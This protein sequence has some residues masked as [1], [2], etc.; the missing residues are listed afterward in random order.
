MADDKPLE[1]TCNC[2]DG[3]ATEDCLVHFFL[4]VRT[5]PVVPL[6][7]QPDGS[8]G[9]PA[10]LPGDLALALA[11]LESGGLGPVVLAVEDGGVARAS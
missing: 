1:I 2:P 9:R 6:A 3:A 5:A 8:A 10:P 7:G 11:H 4:T